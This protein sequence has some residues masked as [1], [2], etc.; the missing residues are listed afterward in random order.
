MSRSRW[1]CGCSDCNRLD[2]RINKDV[3]S[4]CECVLLKVVLK[5]NAR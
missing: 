4:S 3:I 5:V 1:E 2:I